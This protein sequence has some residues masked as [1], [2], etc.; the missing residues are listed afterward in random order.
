MHRRN[1]SRIYLMYK[2]EDETKAKP[3]CFEE[4]SEQI[5]DKWLQ[6]LDREA[7][8]NLSKFLAATLKNIADE[9]NLERK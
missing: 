5:Q 9:F 1:L 6:S 4:C 8:K 7:L 2:S 3:T